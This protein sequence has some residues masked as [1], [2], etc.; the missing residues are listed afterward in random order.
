MGYV[1]I[2]NSDQG[3]P[4]HSIP[5]SFRKLEVTIKHAT[6]IVLYNVP[7]LGTV[8]AFPI[9]PSGAPALLPAI[10]SWRCPLCKQ[11]MPYSPRILPRSCHSHKRA[12]CVCLSVL[13]CI[14]IM[15]PSYAYHWFNIRMWYGIKLV[16]VKLVI[17]SNI[18]VGTFVFSAITIPGGREDCSKVSIEEVGVVIEAYQ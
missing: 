2:K 6:S 9:C 5:R 13:A 17:R 1:K 15:K 3:S 12:L 14:R 16:E 8:L 11:F 18:D 4:S 10:L 7:M